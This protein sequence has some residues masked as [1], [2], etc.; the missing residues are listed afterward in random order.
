MK[1]QYC[2]AGEETRHAVLRTGVFVD[3][4]PGCILRVW[5]NRDRVRRNRQDS[6]FRVH[7]AISGVAHYARRTQGV[8]EEEPHATPVSVGPILPPPP[9]TISPLD[10][11]SRL[12]DQPA[13]IRNHQTQGQ[14]QE[15]VGDSGSQPRTRGVT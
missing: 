8:D 1:L 7:R 14:N 12:L 11:R 10:P 2:R 15:S 4:D 6:V 5:G 13:K 9:R 3:R